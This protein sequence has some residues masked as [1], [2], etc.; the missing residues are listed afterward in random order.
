MKTIG[1]LRLP[2]RDEEGGVADGTRTRNPQHH[3]LEPYQLCYGH[4]AAL[5]LP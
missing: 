2:T 3:K 4:R 1:F 5:N